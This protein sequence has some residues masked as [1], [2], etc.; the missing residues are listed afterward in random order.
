[1]S[2]NITIEGLAPILA[3]L[4]NIKFGA[5]NKILRTA[6]RK[7]SRPILAQ[8]KALCPVE[9]GT[10]RKALGVVGTTKKGIVTYKIGA[11]RDKGVNTPKGFRDP[12]HYI[13]LVELGHIG[14]THA[15]PYPFLRPAYDTQSVQALDIIKISVFE[16][17]EKEA[18]KASAK[19]KTIYKE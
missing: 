5:K 4:E 11:R 14:I 7:G 8:A 10:M 12:V 17:I 18:N 3:A 16:E 9:T 13:H 6:L 15:P 1:M 19:S 2:A